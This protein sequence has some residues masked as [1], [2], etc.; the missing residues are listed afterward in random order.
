MHKLT[1]GDGYAYL[2][3]HV[4]AGDAGLAAGDSLT[5]YYE[6]TGNPHGRW[7]GGGLSALGD[8]R[9]RVG[10]AVSEASMTAVFRDGRDPITFE[11]LGTPY[12]Q[13][14]PDEGW[15]TVAGYDLTFTAPKSVSILWGLADDRT[16]TAL[17]DAHSATRERRPCA[18]LSGRRWAGRCA[19]TRALLLTTESLRA[20]RQD[21][22][23]RSDG[24]CHVSR[25][26]GAMRNREPGGIASKSEISGSRSTK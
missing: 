14:V 10:A 19:K 3:R 4:A 16:R 6:L 18:T 26:S 22:T 24:S 1:V 11:P 17:H 7:I 5:A 15:H 8:G 2:T 21:Q 12:K 13:I 9:L 20:P 25:Y 23:S